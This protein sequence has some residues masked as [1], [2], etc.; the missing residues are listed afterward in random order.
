MVGIK[1]QSEFI[2]RWKCQ[3]Q[4]QQTIYR[5]HSVCLLLCPQLPGGYSTMRTSVPPF[6]DLN[7][8]TYNI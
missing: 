2:I 3:V 7:L 5:W 8:I 4:M 6:R 1:S